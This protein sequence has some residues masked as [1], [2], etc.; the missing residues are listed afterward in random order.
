MGQQNYESAI[1][2]AIR[3][4]APE[5]WRFEERT[6]G[7]VRSRADVRVPR[8]LLE[9]VPKASRLV[10]CRIRRGA[11]LVHRFDLRIPNAS[12]REV[13]TVH[14]LPPLRFSDE[15]TL[16]PWAYRSLKGTEVICPSRFAADEIAELLEA[17]RIHVVPYGV[18]PAFR[19]AEPLS[20]GELESLGVSLPFF[21]HAGG[22][23]VRKNL[24]SLAQAWSVV[25]RSLP[26]HGL[27]LVGA[28][29]AVRSAHFGAL[30]RVALVGKRRLE[31]VARIM[32]SSACV[33]VPST[34]EGFGLPALEGMAV[35]VPVIAARAGA[36]PEVCGEGAIVVDPDANSL[37]DAMI[38]VLSDPSVTAGLQGRARARARQFDWRLAANQHL[39]VYTNALGE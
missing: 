12:G 24:Q 5:G 37:A 35:G 26:S 4:A 15:G 18:R 8:H 16:P 25:S 30:P 23:T 1:Q 11:D 9:R 13:V 7:G 2:Q 38:A 34:Y 21:V 28:S 20:I 19:T 17:D 36:L 14:D 31:E 22:A 27:V 10:G 39:D 33:I 3:E 29:D 32:A 6:F